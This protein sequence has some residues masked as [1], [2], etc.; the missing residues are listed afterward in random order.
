MRLRPDCELVLKSFLMNEGSADVD[1][2]GFLA[3]ID[4][5]PIQ[6]MFS[7]A[8]P[9][10][11]HVYL[12]D[13][14]APASRQQYLD[15]FIRGIVDHH[16][17]EKRYLS[18]AA[19]GHRKVKPVGSCTSLI[20]LELREI[21][22]DSPLPSH[23]ACL[24]LSPI[25]VDTNCMRPEAKRATAQDHEAVRWLARYVDWD[26]LAVPRVQQGQSEVSRVTVCGAKSSSSS[27]SS[28]SVAASEGAVFGTMDA[29]YKWVN[30]AKK[31]VSHLNSL[32]LLRMDYK[33]WTAT[34]AAERSGLASRAWVVGISSAALS[35]PKWQKR[36]GM[37]KIV[38]SI[39]GWRTEKGLDLAILMTHGKTKV[40]D[41]EADE[42][43][44]RFSREL[45]VCCNPAIMEEGSGR[46]FGLIET[47]PTLGLEPYEHK[48]VGKHGIYKDMRH[49]R[50]YNQ[51]QTVASRKQV[52]PIV[53]DILESLDGH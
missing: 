25:L 3:F 48:N 32:D 42:E 6:E 21:L 13:H 5:L 41:S 24:L 51:T 33:Q 37:K 31:K 15:P 34:A 27:S 11:L 22:G 8:N 39:E 47:S 38:A 19:T 44:K 36:D 1:P 40:R 49:V 7:K 43:T 28:D 18:L 52:F 20:A 2:E 14:N 16:A 53:K 35:L 46:F 23:L 29:F 50:V 12:T 45:V 10:K 26:A 9:S 17:D 4:D 30:K